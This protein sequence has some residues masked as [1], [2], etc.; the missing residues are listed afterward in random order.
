MIAGAALVVSSYAVAQSKKSVKAAD[1]S[2]VAAEQS[3][4]AAD[5][6]AVSAESMSKID[7]ARHLEERRPAW[8]VWLD[9]GRRGYVG[10]PRLVLK[11]D[12]VETVD[13]AEVLSLDDGKLTFKESQEGVPFAGDLA[14]TVSPVLHGREVA[15]HVLTPQPPEGGRARVEV[16]STIGGER[17]SNVFEVQLPRRPGRMYSY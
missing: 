7:A 13:H 3:A 15:W 12:S 2:A 5:R 8:E 1:R 16:R 4:V 17:W 9:S 10:P 14:E 6:S 11:L